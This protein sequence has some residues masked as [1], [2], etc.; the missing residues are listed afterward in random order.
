MRLFASLLSAAIVSALWLV[1]VGV[2]IAYSTFVA[3]FGDET[4]SVQERNA[5]WASGYRIQW[6]VIVVLP[7]LLGFSAA[8]LQRRLAPKSRAEWAVLAAVPATFVVLLA[9]LLV[10]YAWSAVLLV[11]WAFAG[12]VLGVH[13]AERGQFGVQL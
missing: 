2:W 4:L 11:V 10:F 8:W 7:P 6:F 13:L 1:L 3:G 9:N 12:V 5:V